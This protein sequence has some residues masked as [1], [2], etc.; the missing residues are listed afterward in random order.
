MADSRQLM[1]EADKPFSF[2][3]SRQSITSCLVTWDGCNPLQ[4]M[5]RC[6]AWR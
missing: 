4:A 3:A 6:H 1:V 5:N 2:I